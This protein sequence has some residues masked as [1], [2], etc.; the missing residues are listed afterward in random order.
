MSAAAPPRRLTRNRLIAAAAVLLLVGIGYFIYMGQFERTDDAQVE[1]DVV[2]L[3][4]R[5]SGQVQQVRVQ[6]NQQVKAGD[7][8]LELDDAE[9]KARVQQAEAELQTARAQA[10][11]VQAQAVVVEATAKG[12]YQSAKAT[13]GGVAN[14]VNG[15][16]AQVIA[17]RAALERA[18]AE[19][20]Q[21]MADLE[22][23]KSLRQANAIPEE[24]LE[25]AQ[26]GHDAAQA[27]LAQAEAQLAGAQEAKSVAESHV[28]EAQGRLGASAP[29]AAQI[30]AAQANA[31]VALA[32]AQAAQA[33]LDVQ[34]LLLAYAHL[35]AP[36]DG[37]VTR[38]TAHPGQ[39]VQPG[40]AVAELVPTQNYVV[41]NFKETQIGRMRPGQA[42]DIEVDAYPGRHLQGKVESVAG[43]TGARFALL[44]PDN[45]SGNFV[46][47]VQRVPVRI[48]WEQLPADVQL[49]AGLSV[50][51]R[52]DVRGGQT[53]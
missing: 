27:A 42:V 36:V 25:R 15:A 24:R 48:A 7:V 31:Q 26:S 47:V 18:R 43:G 14:A 34:R 30:A 41:A 33:H 45:A 6:D 1:A 8:L 23:A 32:A 12:G 5:V 52:V 4:L 46:K 20:H 13:L 19:A 50:E 53:P 39:L 37:F 49:R 21:A 28:G 51:V 44:P 10:E 3:A 35:Q 22:R 38:L 2:P 29:I 11:A 16:I 9:L 40:Q 17:S